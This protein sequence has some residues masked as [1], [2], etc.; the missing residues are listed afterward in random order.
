M[1]KN[2]HK[3]RAKIETPFKAYYKVIGKACGCSSKYA[4]LIL[5]D[6]PLGTYKGKVY[7]KRDTPLTRRIKEKAQE[8][9]QFLN[10]N[11]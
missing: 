2:K 4:K 9:E 5:E 1:T 8:L 10:S 6:L 3:S 7:M 11:R